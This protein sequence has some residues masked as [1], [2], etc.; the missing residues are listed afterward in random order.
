[1]RFK[2]KPVVNNPSNV[3]PLIPPE[4]IIIGTA[5]SLLATGGLAYFGNGAKAVSRGDGVS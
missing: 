2:I 5:S 4:A 1:M 3:Q